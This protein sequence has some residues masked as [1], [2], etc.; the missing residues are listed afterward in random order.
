MPEA[1]AQNPTA[2][3]AR[4]P[5]TVLSPNIAIINLD[6]AEQGARLVEAIVRGEVEPH[7]TALG[8]FG[9]TGA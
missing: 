3:R 1:V 8:A 5:L 6:L 7:L 9:D 2:D 4:P